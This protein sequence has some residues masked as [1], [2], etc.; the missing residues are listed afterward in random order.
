M[1]FLCFALRGKVLFLRLKGRD[2]MR[3]KGILTFGWLMP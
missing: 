2:F 3:V 1:F